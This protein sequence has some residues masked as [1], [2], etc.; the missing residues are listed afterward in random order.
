MV[1]VGPLVLALAQ[2]LLV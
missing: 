1:R 2:L